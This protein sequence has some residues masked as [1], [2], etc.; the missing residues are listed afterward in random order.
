MKTLLTE[1]QVYKIHKGDN[2]SARTVTY[3]GKIFR[4]G[5][6]WFKC[7]DKIVFLINK[8]P[9]CKSKNTYHARSQHVY[10]LDPMRLYDNVYKTYSTENARSMLFH[11]I[12]YCLDCHKEFSIEMYIYKKIRLRDYLAGRY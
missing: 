9:H 5:F 10:G 12:D 7:V 11:K 2:H 3:I 4:R 8:C 6:K 1:K